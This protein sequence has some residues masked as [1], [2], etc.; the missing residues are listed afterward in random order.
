MIRG[1][2]I[3]L[4][5]EGGVGKTT[6]IATLINAGLEVFVI[7]TDPGGEESLIEGCEVHDADVSKM[8]WKY[9]SPAA[10]PWES[11]GNMADDMRRNSYED[12]SKQKHNKDK[13]HMQQFAEVISACETP[14]CDCCTGDPFQWGPLEEWGDDR[15]F[16]IDGLSGLNAMARDCMA[17]TKPVMHPGEW[18]A[19][20]IL[21]EKFIAKVC[22]DVP[23]PVVLI[24]HEEREIDEVHGGG[25]KIMV[26]AL[27][28]RLA[29][30]LP[31]LFSDCVHAYREGS[32]FYWSTTTAG[33]VT[34]ARS[35]PLMDKMA[36]DFTP[37]I[38][39]WKERQQAKEKAA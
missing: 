3:L 36:P 5:G 25:A 35:L 24:A 29:P 6:A 1:P 7:C 33:V 8:H 22:A 39:K 28:K 16:V 32:K 21:E 2:K 17:G 23:C 12:L 11:L 34:K 30:K 19:A 13:K 27:G 4:A 9:I 18:G 31:R 20:M 38:E 26:S 14:I 37:V 15:A 10:M